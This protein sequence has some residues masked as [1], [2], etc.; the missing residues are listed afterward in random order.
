MMIRSYIA[1]CVVLGGMVLGAAV[2]P[3]ATA[4]DA[5]QVLDGFAASVA[6]STSAT[7]EQKRVVAE[8]VKQLRQTPEDR[9]AAITESLPLLHPDLKSALA[10]MG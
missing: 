3:V 6:K 1:R 10:A 2:G 5:N 8:L 7:E 4:S 9:A